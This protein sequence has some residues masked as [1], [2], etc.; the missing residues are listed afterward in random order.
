MAIKFKVIQKGYP[1][2]AGG[3][4]K[5]FYASTQSSGE[6]T[7][8]GLTKQIEK[9]STVSGADIRAVVYATVDV[10]KDALAAGQI[11][12]LGELGSLRVSISSEGKATEEEVGGTSIRKAKVV[13]TPGQDLKDML[14]TL[15]YE[16]A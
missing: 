5:K 14:I 1:G 3:G 2:V 4:E 11:V 16:K 12:R 8:N 6:L 10:M 9:I 7:L 13:F 15:N